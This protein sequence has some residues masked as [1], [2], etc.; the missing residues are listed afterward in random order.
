M[1]VRLICYIEMKKKAFCY[2]YLIKKYSLAKYIFR[3]VGRKNCFG[4]KSP[5]IIQYMYQ[6]L[7]I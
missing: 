3:K 6:I 7:K 5:Q 2:L 4:K 1:L